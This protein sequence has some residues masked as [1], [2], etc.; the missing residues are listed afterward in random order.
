MLPYFVFPLIACH[1]ALSSLFQMNFLGISLFQILPT[2]GPPSP[3][4]LP[5]PGPTAPA[6]WPRPLDPLALLPPERADKA[7]RATAAL[8][9]GLTSRSSAQGVARHAGQSCREAH[10]GEDLCSR[11]P[12]PATK[13]LRFRSLKPSGWRARPER[14]SS[15]FTFPPTLPTSHHVPHLAWGVGRPSAGVS[16]MVAGPKEG[17]Q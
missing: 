14:P 6:L 2:P 15:P 1:K 8:P 11:P 7:R 5:R 10:G 4:A 16:S 9:Q 12:T 13:H 3:A 17:L